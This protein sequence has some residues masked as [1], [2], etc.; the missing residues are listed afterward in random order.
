MDKHILTKQIQIEGMGINIYKTVPL[1]PMDM[2]TLLLKCLPNNIQGNN[3]KNHPDFK[4]MFDYVESIKQNNNTYLLSLIY[5]PPC[6]SDENTLGNFFGQKMNN[7]SKDLKIFPFGNSIISHNSLVSKRTTYHQTYIL[8]SLKGNKHLHDNHPS[9]P[10]EDGTIGNYIVNNWCNAILKRYITYVNTYGLNTCIDKNFLKKLDK[11]NSSD[12]T[13]HPDRDHPDRDHP[14]RDHQDPDHPDPDHQDP[15]HQDP[16]HIYTTNIIQPITTL[17][18]LTDK[19]I[20]E[21]KEISNDNKC[22]IIIE[23]NIIDVECF[24]NMQL[25]IYN[26]TFNKYQNELTNLRKFIVY[27]INNKGIIYNDV[28]NEFSHDFIASLLGKDY[29]NM[30]KSK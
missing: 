18:A 28:I 19:Q 30:L 24:K 22:D 4:H 29:S 25:S 16:D 12:V 26:Y 6:P 3:R 15:D 11:K 23:N 21:N 27:L 7:I 9:N 5:F 13:C 17:S 8:V 10:S 20:N 2:Y 1:K 14:D